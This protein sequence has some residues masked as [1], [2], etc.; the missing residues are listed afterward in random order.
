MTELDRLGRLLGR[1]DL[2]PLVDALARR[3]ALGR[4]LSGSIDVRQASAAQREAIAALFGRRPARST[5]VRVDLDAL[6]AIVRNSGAAE[7]LADAVAGLR[8]PIESRRDSAAAEHRAWDA[9][10]STL[11]A[12]AEQRTDHAEW[13]AAAIARGTIRRV[14][15]APEVA[16]VVLPRVVAVLAAL[17]A[18][19]EALPRFAARVLGSAHALDAGTPEASL[20]LAALARRVATVGAVRAEEPS[21]RTD[22]RTLWASVGVVLDELSSTVLVHALELPGPLG[23][24]TAAGEPVVI[25]LRQVRA[26]RIDTP[27]RVVF[28]CENPSVVDAA[29]RGLGS[30]SAPLICVQGQPSLAAE[31]LLQAV[32]GAGIHYHGDFDWGGLRIANRLHERYGIE[33]WRFRAADLEAHAGLA[34]EPL[35]GEA[36]DARWDPELRAALERRGRRLEEE[37][38]LEELVGDLAHGAGPTS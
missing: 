33:P 2:V 24:L 35:T 9:A 14:T 1:A 4:P 27:R 29:A 30:S 34:G 21:G 18:D 26:L 19:G 6:S 15:R 23:D 36:V 22:R 38:V 11:L 7:S 16:S 12:F 31:V 20:V 13:V 10:T 28:A 37:H 3:I 8:G 25:T 17:P 32:A 5:T